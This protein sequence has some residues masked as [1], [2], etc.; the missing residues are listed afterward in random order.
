MQ[1]IR[2]KIWTLILVAFWFLA[3]AILTPLNP[4]IAAVVAD[5]GLI[6]NPS[7]AGDAKYD[8][9][10]VKLINN[11]KFKRLILSP[12][13][14]H[15][16]GHL[17]PNSVI[18][19]DQYT[20]DAYITSDLVRAVGDPNVY[21][22]YPQGDAGERRWI[23]TAQTFNSYGYDWDSVYE[24][25]QVDRDEYILG[26]AIESNNV[27]ACEYQN[28][29]MAFILVSNSSNP[30]SQDDID[31]VNSLKQKVPETFA[32]ATNNLASI[33]TSYPTVFLTIEGT[34]DTMGV[35]REFYKSHSDD[36]HF[37]TI[38][39]TYNTNKGMHHSLARNN[40]T[41]IGLNTYD[42]TSSY[43]SSGKLLGVNWID[44]IDKYKPYD[45]FYQTLGV[46]GILH[47]T[48]HQW[49]AYVD[50]IDS[51][52]QRSDSLR[53]P[54]N[55]A[56]WDKKMET[57]Y[58]LLNG[59]SWTNNENGTFTAKTK[60]DNRNTYSNLDLYLMGLK[61]KEQVG[62]INLIVSSDDTAYIQ[63]GTTISGSTKTISVDQIINAEGE[64][65]CVP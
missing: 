14:F 59:F 23:K 42:S 29:K 4:S 31:T 25:N 57:G 44:Y 24:I 9:Y 16:Y 48:T 11:K 18:E 27:G 32:W 47:E 8:I 20:I 56:H 38:F 51:N 64:R 13:V 19:V 7:A 12:K 34:L 50:F 40:I 22:L 60:T 28:Y 17:D 37:I 35:T 63:P 15:S 36:F 58:D 5:G 45:D 52:G 30:A 53:N 54:Y 6:R 2:K 26:S 41:G 3:M 62:S 1:K 39:T 10:I 55:M 49:G 43:G 33:D 61:S 46:N 65:K 21:K